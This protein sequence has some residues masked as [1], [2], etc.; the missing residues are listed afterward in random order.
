MVSYVDIVRD[1]IKITKF[2]SKGCREKVVEK[3]LTLVKKSFS[4]FKE[5]MRLIRRKK[6]FGNQGRVLSTVFDFADYYNY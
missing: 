2:M 3:Q 6:C 1:T 5:T 4:K